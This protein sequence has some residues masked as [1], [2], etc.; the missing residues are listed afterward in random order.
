VTL[1][2]RNSAV[3]TNKGKPVARGAESNTLDP[4]VA[5]KLAKRLIEGLLLT[6]SSLDLAA[7][8]FPDCTVED[9][10]LEVSGGSGKKLVVGVPCNTSDSAAVLLN[11]L[12]NPPVVLLL[13]VADRN[14]LGA[15]SNSELV[16]FRAPLYVSSGTVDTKDNQ[17]WL[18]FA[19]IASPH[20]SVTILGASYDTVVDTIPVDASNN[21]V[22]LLQ[23]SLSYPRSALLG[24][25]D[26][27]IVV[28]AQSALAAVSIP[29]MA[30]DALTLG[31]SLHFYYLM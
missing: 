21:T 6:P 18:P 2:D 19:T 7:I 26:N 28:G 10:G 4:T 15:A 14:N 11:V 3:V 30:C 27:I 1:S 12:A 20:I 23:S 25:N 16:T 13:K 8:D 5:V 31:N 24:S 9:T 17:H 22:V 29:G